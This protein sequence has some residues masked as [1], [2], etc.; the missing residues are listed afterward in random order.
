MFGNVKKS[1]YVSFVIEKDMKLNIIEIIWFGMRVL[2][3]L[4]Y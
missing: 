2:K 4:G 1:S 3:V